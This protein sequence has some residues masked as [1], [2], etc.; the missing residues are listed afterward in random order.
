MKKSLIVIL[1][2]VVL[3][4]PIIIIAIVYG[5]KN[6]NIFDN[7]DFWYGYMAYFGTVL[8]ATVSLWQNKAF[9]DEN[10]NAQDRLERIHKQ[11]NEINVI[12]KILEFEHKRIHNLYDYLDDF[13]KA[14]HYNNIAIAF[15]GCI[16]EKIVITQARDKCDFLFLAITREL[17]IDKRDDKAKD[18][19]LKTSEDMYNAAL[20]LLKAYESKKPDVNK[21]ENDLYLVW[22]EF[23]I[24]K[25]E[26]INSA[27]KDFQR[28]LYENLTLDEIQNIYHKKTKESLK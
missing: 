23:F 27:Q 14:C 9:K 6:I 10:D 24:K 5:V 1:S 16:S 19:L 12:N 25:E 22:K 11:A 20:K 8:L 3:F 28:L 15:H 21:C 17:R 7:P 2:I 13:E 4:I 18:D 26:Y